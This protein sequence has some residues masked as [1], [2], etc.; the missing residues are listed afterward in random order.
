MRDAG[1]QEYRYKRSGGRAANYDE[2]Q[3]EIQELVDAAGFKNEEVFLTDEQLLANI[4]GLQAESNIHLS[5]ELSAPFGRCA[6]DVEMETGTGKT[7]VY[8]KTIFELNKRYGWSKFIVVVPSVAIREGVNKTFEMTA[9]HFMEYYGKKARFF[10]YDSDHLQKLDDF[11]SDAGINVMIINTQAFAKSMNEDN[12][13][14]GRGGDKAARIIYTKRDEFGSRRPI[15]VIAANRPIV[16]LDEPQKMGGAATQKGIKNFHPLFSLNYSAT[17]VKKHNLVYVLDALDAYNKRLVKK[18]EVKGFEVRNLTGTSTYIYLDDILLSPDKPPRARL[19]IE[20]A[21]KNGIKREYRIFEQGDSLY[22]ASGELEQYNGLAVTN[23]DVFGGAVEFSNGLSLHKGESSGDMSEESLRRAQ[24]RE[25]IKSHFEKEEELF[26]KGIKTL[27]LFF[28]DEVAKY[29]QYDGEGNELPGEYG[30][31]FEEEYDAVLND[32]REGFS[33]EYERYLGASSAHEAHRGYF[34]IDKQGHSI[35]SKP[36][37]KKEDISDDISAY[38]L[39]LKNK[40]RLLSFDEPTRFIFSHSALREGWDNPN[41]FQICTLKHG[42]DSTTQKRQEV[43]RG[44]RLCVNQEGTR[45]D[46]ETLGDDVQNVN[47]LT[48][49]AGEKYADFVAGLQREIKDVLYERPDEGDGGLFR[50]QDRMDGW[51]A[52]KGERETGSRLLSVSCQA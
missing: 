1:T 31:M 52:R 26:Q 29:R 45:M 17:H 24:I 46:A 40:E 12:N 19:E 6:L 30:R 9:E 25:T 20:A 2:R 7:Y 41:V 18:I 44:M 4:R 50:G 35:N 13:V 11:S 10:V 3:A 33:P 36:R 34:S 8:I 37:S 15:D 51:Q 48:V 39:I 43:G 23:I 5:D 32:L 38:D 21:H 16:I 47:K 14:E 22:H 28:I 27:S 42:G 49:I